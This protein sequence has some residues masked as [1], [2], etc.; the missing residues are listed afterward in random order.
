[1]APSL[2]ARVATLA[3]LP[4]LALGACAIG[5]KLVNHAFGFNVEQDSPGHE[6]LAYRYGAGVVPTTS[7]DTSIRQFGRSR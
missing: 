3:L 2:Q 6:V 7:S 1:M 4:A 5:P